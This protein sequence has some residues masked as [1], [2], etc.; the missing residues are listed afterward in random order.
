MFGWALKTSLARFD[1]RYNLYLYVREIVLHALFICVDDEEEEQ[2]IKYQQL[3]NDLPCPNKTLLGW[4]FTHFAHV[5]EKVDCLVISHKLKYIF[6][7]SKFLQYIKFVQSVIKRCEWY[8]CI[9]PS[10]LMPFPFIKYLFKLV[11]KELEQHLEYR[12][13]V[14]SVIWE[15]I[16]YM[17][18]VLLLTWKLL[19]R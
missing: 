12:F 2:L 17:L 11:T 18:V 4:L 5:L 1:F 9:M 14:F 15:Q 3:M 7:N 19:N 16:T 13:S 8:D 10:L 6:E